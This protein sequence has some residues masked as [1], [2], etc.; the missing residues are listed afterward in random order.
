MRGR[1]RARHTKS[2]KSHATNDGDM[3]RSSEERVTAP[4]MLCDAARRAN[5]EPY[6]KTTGIVWALPDLAV[7]TATDDPGAE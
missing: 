2:Q 4:A 1:V 7:T 3:H 6:C 5:M